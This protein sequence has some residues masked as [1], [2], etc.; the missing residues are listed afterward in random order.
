[1]AQTPNFYENQRNWALFDKILPNAENR[2]GIPVNTFISRFEVSNPQVKDVLQKYPTLCYMLGNISSPAEVIVTDKHP[3]VR[4]GE[5]KTG[6]KISKQLLMEGS[7]MFGLKDKDDAKEWKG[8]FNH[9]VG[10]ARHTFFLFNRLSEAI[11]KDPK[12]KEKLQEAGFDFSEFDKLDAETLRDFMFMDHLTRRQYDETNWYQ[13]NDY[14]KEWH[15][16]T[17]VPGET[18][19]A[20]LE[21]YQ[22][23]QTFIDLI[24]VENHPNHL[25]ESA[26]TEGNKHFPN[27]VD[28]LLTYADWTFEQG[29]MSLE[30]RFKKLKETRKDISP[31]LLE[32]L[33]SCGHVF[34]N[35]MNVIF[36]TNIFEE[37][38]SA[39]PYD[40]ETEIRTV[41]GAPSG[42]SLKETF[43]GYLQQFPQIE[44]S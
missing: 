13:L 23:D 26:T 3:A 6:D 12:I 25:A 4:K 20:L 34:E 2:Y 32:V 31:E 5:I 10:S 16:E 24:R 7:G 36:E 41:Y 39:G 40:W 43:P 11:K 42:L 18:A 19:K 38:K 33:E 35:T 21:K 30:E 9:T 15:P 29:P 8:I 44:E 17:S 27:I 1:M 14:Q 28:A 37:L 22:A